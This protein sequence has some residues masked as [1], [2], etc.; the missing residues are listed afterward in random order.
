MKNKLF[1][2]VMTLVALAFVLL[3]LLAFGQTNTPSAA[4]SPIPET[5][6]PLLEL[7]QGKG[8]VLTTLIAWTA[9]I[10]VILAPFAVWIRNKLA[11]AANRAAET[12]DEDDDA[13]LRKLFSAKWYRLTA[14]LLNFAN[15]RLP[16]ITELERALELQKQAVAKAKSQ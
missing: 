10:S 15:I 12:A 13:Y 4:A 6:G 1:A 11:D 8:T 9:A 5:F 3:P 16:T 7:L 2:I 14:F